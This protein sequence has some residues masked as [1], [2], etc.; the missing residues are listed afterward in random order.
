MVTDGLTCGWFR[1]A[2]YGSAGIEGDHGAAF[3][4]VAGN[5][6]ADGRTDFYV[7]NDLSREPAVA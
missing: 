5:F 7:A 1:A 4:V 2:R 3:G 6:N